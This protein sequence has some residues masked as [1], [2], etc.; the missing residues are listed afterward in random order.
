MD[1]MGIVLG[2]YKEEEYEENNS[3]INDCAGC[4]VISWV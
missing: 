2:E 1:E 4:I 3:G